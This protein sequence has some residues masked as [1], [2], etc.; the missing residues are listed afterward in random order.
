MD[1]AASVQEV[2]EEIVTRLARTAKELTGSRNLVMAGG[3]AL[4]CVANGKLLRSGEF[5]GLWIHPAA[6]DAG[7]A[8][9]A[10][11]V[12]EYLWNNGTRKPRDGKDEM[13]GSLLGPRYSN[14]EIKRFLDG[15]GAQYRRIDDEEELCEYVAELM[16]TE[17]VVGWMQ[18]RMEFGPRA[19]GSRSIVGDARSEAMNR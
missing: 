5:D 17:H 8:L 11:Y 3:V 15:V 16:A 10:A 13:R 18:G 6:G 1:V 14:D 4:N 12:T 7:G 19:L 9:G 2:T